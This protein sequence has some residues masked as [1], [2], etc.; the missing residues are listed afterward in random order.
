MEAAEI[1]ILMTRRAVK[2]LG[3]KHTLIQH[4]VVKKAKARVAVA[5]F[6]VNSLLTRMTVQSPCCSILQT[7]NNAVA[8]FCISFKYLGLS[9]LPERSKTFLL[10]FFF[11]FLLYSENVEDKH[12]QPGSN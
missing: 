4:A 7:T 5:E 2:N 9:P 10:S 1:G 3:D 6:R 11:F 8:S 12:G